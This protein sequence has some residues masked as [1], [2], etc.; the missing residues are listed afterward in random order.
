MEVSKTKTD[1]KEKTAADT[2]IERRT[3]T[4][5]GSYTTKIQSFSLTDQ[6]PTLNFFTTTNN[7]CLKLQLPLKNLSVN[8]RDF[9]I[10]TFGTT[11]NEINTETV[12]KNTIE[13]QFNDDLT[14]CNHTQTDCEFEFKEIEPESIPDQKHTPE[15]V[16][17]NIKTALLESLYQTASETNVPGIEVNVNTIENKKDKFV[18]TVN[19]IHGITLTWEL[20]VPSLTEMKTSA[21]AT[22]IE[23]QGGGD[24]RQIDT[25]GTVMLIKQEDKPDELNTITTQKTHQWEI[26]PP[27]TYKKYWRKNNTK[28]QK[29]N[30]THKKI[31]KNS[32][33]QGSMVQTKIKWAEKSSY[34]AETSQHVK[35]SVIRANR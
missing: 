19:P 18:L 32:T 26:L 5:G 6:P 17:N 2:Y 34:L 24:P 1:T 30:N 16:T 14:E 21:I 15:K 29:Q 10:N 28:T 22:F 9:L 33:Q 3:L 13:I 12:N 11:N 35:N 4:T 31:N 8:R 27:T 20:P 23:N 7:R 25:H